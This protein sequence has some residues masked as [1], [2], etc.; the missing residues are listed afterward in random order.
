MGKMRGEIQLLGWTAVVISL[1]LILVFE[2][3]A[4]PLIHMLLGGAF[5]PAVRIGRVAIVGALP[6]ALYYVLRNVVDAF[7]ER[8]VNTI[9]LSVA[10]FVFLGVASLGIRWPQNAYIPLWSF[11]VATTV[12]ASLTVREVRSI[13]QS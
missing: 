4:A 10:L 8:A 5:D 11:I 13:L 2:F 12:L 3:F 7:H 6:L 1:T 9:Y